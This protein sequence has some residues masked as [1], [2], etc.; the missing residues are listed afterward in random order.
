[1][2]VWLENPDK[3]WRIVSNR[4]RWHREGSEEA[5]RKKQQPGDIRCW[6]SLLVF[7]QSSREKGLPEAITVL[8]TSNVKNV[9]APVFVP[10]RPTFFLYFS[11]TV[12]RTLQW[13]EEIKQLAGGN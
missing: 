2:Q 5:R 10:T 9:Q 1:M 3:P 6:M 13:Q 8:E 4:L 11:S 7:L 12:C